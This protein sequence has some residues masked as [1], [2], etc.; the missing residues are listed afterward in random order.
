[1][2]KEHYMSRFELI[3]LAGNMGM[4][5]E[6]A[7]KKTPGELYDFICSPVEADGVQDV[8]DIPLM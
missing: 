1:M 6:T 2:R 4:D 3:M 5:P 7:E 8:Y